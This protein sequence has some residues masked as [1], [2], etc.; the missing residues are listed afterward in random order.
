MSVFGVL[1]VAMKG[2]MN[3]IIATVTPFQTKTDRH[4]ESTNFCG[5][6]N[7][8]SVNKEMNLKVIKS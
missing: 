8:L 4:D 1:F 3:E 7:E 6:E 2:F 5:D